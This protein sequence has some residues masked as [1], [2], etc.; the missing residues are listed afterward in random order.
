MK[1]VKFEEIEAWQEARKLVN[2]IYELTSK[3]F[4]QKDF[5]LREQIQNL[6]TI[7]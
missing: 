1:I 5:G 6:R 2:M 3:A 7:P 4:F